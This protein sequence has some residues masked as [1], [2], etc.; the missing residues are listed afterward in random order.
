MHRNVIGFSRAVRSPLKATEWLAR[1]ATSRTEVLQSTLKTLV[2]CRTRSRC[3][4]HATISC[5]IAGRCGETTDASAS[6]SCNSAHDVNGRS[7]NTYASITSFGHGASPNHDHQ[8]DD[9]E[10]GRRSDCPR[11]TEVGTTTRPIASASWRAPSDVRPRG[12]A[13]CARTYTDPDWRRLPSFG[14]NSPAV[15]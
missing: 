2:Y 10:R 4:F 6:P 8:R 9:R 3:R 11:R 15:R 12:A 7:H 1:F 14:A 13:I 5:A